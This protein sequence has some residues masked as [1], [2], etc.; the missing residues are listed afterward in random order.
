[1]GET[2]S[3]FIDQLVRERLIAKRIAYAGPGLDRYDLTEAGRAFRDASL[4]QE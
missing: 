1:M 3:N 4:K 2:N